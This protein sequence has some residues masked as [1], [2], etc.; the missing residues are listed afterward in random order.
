MNDCG[1]SE[2]DDM[3]INGK[4]EASQTVIK[5]KL[6]RRGSLG[7]YEMSGWRYL[8]DVS[9]HVKVWPVGRPSGWIDY[10]VA[11][12]IFELKIV[13]PAHKEAVMHVIGEWE[14][15]R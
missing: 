10:T 14:A 13:A 12:G 3:K 1:Q 8:E 11:A 5:G 15:E 6:T 7:G 4:E 2:K 9:W